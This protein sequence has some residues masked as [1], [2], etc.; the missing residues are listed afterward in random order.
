MPDS[1]PSEPRIVKIR[2]Q[3]VGPLTRSTVGSASDP[4][5]QVLNDVL[6]WIWSWRVQVVRL[7]ESFDAEWSDARGLDRRQASSRFSFDEHMLTVT[8][9][10][11]A[12][13][14]KRAQDFF[15]T[16]KLQE[17][18]AEALRLL[19]HLYEHW[20]EQRE[21]FQSSSAPKQQS[22]AKFLERFPHGKPWSIVFDENDWILGG[23]VPLNEVSRALR[24]LEQAV[25]QLETQNAA[26][27]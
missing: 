1:D 17:D 7:R 24:E 26:R 18:H 3:G 22:A 16:I 13:A 6:H 2:I 27:E 5:A 8:G 14:I 12:R 23:V 9:W 19:R 10:N 11:L 15:P 21:A 25:L 4:E 20:D